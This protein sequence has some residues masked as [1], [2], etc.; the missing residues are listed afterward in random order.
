[1]RISTQNDQNDFTITII[2]HQKIK[3]KNQARKEDIKNYT[4]RN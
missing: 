4:E 2:K 3:K 1:M